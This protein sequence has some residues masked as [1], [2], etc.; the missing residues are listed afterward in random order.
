MCSVRR[1]KVLLALNQG[2]LNQPTVDAPPVPAASTEK[3]EVVDLVAEQRAYRRVGFMNEVMSL[4]ASIKS[5]K[6]EEERKKDEK[7]ARRGAGG[8][9][10]R[11]AA[12]IGCSRR[13]G[14]ARA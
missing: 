14:V 9:R 3:K 8:R 1:D 2:N 7:C 10:G 5:S 11:G 6:E 12:R 13:A 4:Q